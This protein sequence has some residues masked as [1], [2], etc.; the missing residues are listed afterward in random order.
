[1]PSNDCL[2]F[3]LP[4]E[5]RDEIYKQVALEDE[6]FIHFQSAGQLTSRMPLTHVSRQIREEYEEALYSIAPTIKTIVN[7][8]DFTHILNFF[9]KLS[10]GELKR[11]PGQ[12]GPREL[13]ITLKL[14]SQCR[15]NLDKLQSWLV[16]FS[17]ATIINISTTYTVPEG[18]LAAA[19]NEITQFGKA[20]TTVSP[21]LV[22][23]I[24]DTILYEWYRTDPSHT[25]KTEMKKICEVLYA[26]EGFI[27]RIRALL[28][29]VRVQQG[30]EDC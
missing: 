26:L 8:F 1:M 16:Q 6:A 27:N 13:Q 4:R 24:L 21:I 15:D 29:S 7:D 5:L 9:D 30:F 2:F 20:T 17:N 19:P 10:D 23:R 12:K 11:L 14:T 18:P 3:R 22:M 25:R 28:S